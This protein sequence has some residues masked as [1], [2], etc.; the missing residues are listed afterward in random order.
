MKIR[1]DQAQHGIDI[2]I[3][4]LGDNQQDL[5]EA[6]QACQEGRCTCPTD[7]YKKLESLDILPGDDSLT[8]HLIVKP[9]EALDSAEIEGCLDHTQRQIAGKS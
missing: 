5:L 4:E 7:E 6:F 2:Q 1:I 9:G 8:L 3:G